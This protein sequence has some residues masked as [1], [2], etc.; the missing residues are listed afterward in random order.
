VS[1][2]CHLEPLRK[3]V[4]AEEINEAQMATLAVEGMGCVHCA[5]RVRNG[6]LNLDGVVSANIDLATGLAFVDY[7][8]AR[9]NRAALIQAV[10]AA[11]HDGHHIYRASISG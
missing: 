5:T 9:T 7:I 11:G 8:P 4:T 6:L 3:H 10:A 2:N 1:D